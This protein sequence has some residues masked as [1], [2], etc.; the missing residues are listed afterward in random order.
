M[1]RSDYDNGSP[2]RFSWGD[3]SYRE[4]MGQLS[5]DEEEKL[6]LRER[7]RANRAKIAKD[8]T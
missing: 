2:K 1:N 7:D 6:R 4:M 3:Q 5:F 8:P